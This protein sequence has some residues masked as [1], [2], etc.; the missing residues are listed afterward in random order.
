MRK[1]ALVI[2]GASVALVAGMTSAQAATDKTPPGVPTAVAAYGHSSSTT[3]SALT[4][5]WHKPTAKDLRGVSVYRN[6]TNTVSHS[7]RVATLSTAS[8]YVDRA[9]K[10]GKLYWYFLRAFDKTGNASSYAM[11]PVRISRDSSERALAGVVTDSTL[12]RLNEINVNVQRGYGNTY[13][14]S[15]STDTAG[16]YSFRD[17]PYTSK[18]VALCFDASGSG[19]AGTSPTGYLSECYSDKPYNAAKNANRL[20]LTAGQYRGVTTSLTSAGGL[21]GVVEQPGSSTAGV[22]NVDVQVYDSEGDEFNDTSTDSNGHW[23]MDG[24]PAGTQYTVLLDASN[25]T[26]DSNSAEGF[27]SQWVGP[28][29]VAPNSYTPGAAVA[30]SSVT[31]YTVTAGQRKAVT[32]THLVVGGSVS[33]TATGAQDAYVRVYDAAGHQLGNTAEV[34]SD[35]GNGDDYKI[36]GVP[37]GDVTVCSGP[38]DGTTLPQCYDGTANG[39]PWDEDTNDFPSAAV[40]AV[41]VTA[42]SETSGVDFTLQHAGSISGH[43]TG[44]EDAIVTVINSNGDV[45]DNEFVGENDGNN[46]NYES[47]NLVPGNYTVCA[48]DESDASTGECWNGTTDTQ[49]AWDGGDYP[50]GTEG[51]THVDSGQA[52]TGVDFAITLS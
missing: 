42:N 28:S 5:S 34:G 1:S 38:Y 23:S 13:Y 26:T 30:P 3:K 29:R 41:T 20:P 22:E 32:T 10:P 18:G 35:S 2:L 47:D 50:A 49:V 24:V 19:H 33:G 51:S 8:S 7:T 39:Q 4:L 37:A 16:Y 12:H 40:G 48:A 14:D 46:G 25:A 11:V 9:V 17:V 31:A 45:V 52:T 15:A 36:S 27:V 6:T 44:T 43:V 21:S